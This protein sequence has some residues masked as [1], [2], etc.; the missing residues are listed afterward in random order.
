VST[1]RKLLAVVALTLSGL[2][3]TATFVPAHACGFVACVAKAITPPQWH[4]AIDDVDRLNGGTGRVV[5]L[6]R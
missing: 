6:G 5:T 1:M 3:S 2:G 4:A